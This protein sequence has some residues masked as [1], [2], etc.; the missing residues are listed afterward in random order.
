MEWDAWCYLSS[1]ATRFTTSPGRHRPGHAFLIDEV[2][3]GGPIHFVSKTDDFKAFAAELLAS[4]FDALDQW[5]NP[6]TNR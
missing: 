4:G 2:L 1:S 5:E 6:P 3:D